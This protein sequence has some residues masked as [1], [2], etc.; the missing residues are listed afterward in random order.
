MSWQWILL[1]LIAIVVIA[2]ILLAKP[3]KVGLRTA[4]A[5]LDLGVSY[6]QN[7]KAIR[8]NILISEVTYSSGDRDIAANLYRPDDQR[9]HS[10]LILAHGAV[11]GGKDDRALRF[12]G[13]SLA[14]AG[15]V[16]L[17]PQLDNLRNFRLHQ[18]DIDVLVASFQYLARQEFSNGKIGILGICLS[19]PLALLAATEPS[20]NQDVAVVSSWGGF[21]N[22]NDW[23][24][25]VI[26][27]RYIDEGT[28]KPWWPRAVL[29]EETP[30]WLI[31]LLPDP[32]DRVCIEEM[33]RGNSTDSVKSNLSPSGRAMYELLTNRDPE[34]VKD[35][36][37]R[38]DPKI[39]QTLNNL[40]PHLKIAQLK[41]KIAIIHTFT[42]DVIPWV[43]SCKLAGAIKDENKIY[44]R[45]FRQFYHVSI[46]DLLKAR[47]SNLYNVISEAVQ[48]YLY[49]YSI[50]YQL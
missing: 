43:E 32:S 6:K 35:L 37:A 49:M 14:R 18:D 41:T 50:L 26:S 7:A 11:K 9:R 25:A 15:Y 12:A 34:R 30:K 4:A 24:Q 13:Q 44:F 8:K 42:D 33:L 36:W 39:L 47:I 31:E 2:I 17:V 5:I 20:I 10:G 28:A 23:L 3:V 19:A 48:F 45:V 22:I 27:E 21:Y 1:S 46:E 16:A 29:I 38:L 40:S